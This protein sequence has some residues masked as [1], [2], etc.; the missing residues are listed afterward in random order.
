MTFRH[1]D[2]RGRDILSGSPTRVHAIPSCLAVVLSEDDPR[3]DNQT[4]DIDFGNFTPL[5]RYYFSRINALV[6]FP[7]HDIVHS[8][9]FSRFE[10]IKWKLPRATCSSLD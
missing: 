9:S 10:N 7:R 5:L 2:D 8:G 6:P 3:S 4:P 1:T